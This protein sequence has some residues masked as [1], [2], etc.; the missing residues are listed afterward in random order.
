LQPITP[1]AAQPNALPA[2]PLALK[3]I[4]VPEQ[5]TNYPLAYGWWI[6]AAILV[7]AI[8]VTVIKSRKSAKHNQV[9]KQALTQLK[10]NSE[11]NNSELIS[12]LKW[13]AMHYFSR[14]ELAKLYGDS[15][16]QFL[17][18]QLPQKHRDSFSELSEQAFKS[19]YQQD[20]HNQVDNQ[21]HQAA[22]LW[23][24]KA[25]PPV[26]EKHLNPKSKGVSS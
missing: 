22:H 23:L 14:R 8:V 2:N 1:S 9:K 18:E 15:L 17:L 10:S 16:Q 11:L 4:H 5:I 20:I 13:A 6:L 24:T 21:F 25:L 3:D 12:L 19:Q 7:L 26:S